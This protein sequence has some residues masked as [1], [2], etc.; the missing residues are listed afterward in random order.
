MKIEVRILL[1]K[2]IALCLLFLGC[3]TAGAE[4]LFSMTPEAE[5]L[6]RQRGGVGYLYWG[7]YKNC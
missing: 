2:W 5:A 4:T 7:S 1:R 6:F 3:S